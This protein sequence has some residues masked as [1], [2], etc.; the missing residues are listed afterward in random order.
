MPGR[1][2]R[3]IARTC[4]DCRGNNGTLGGDW[5]RWELCHGGV[6]QVMNKSDHYEQTRAMF[7]T[8][9]VEREGYFDASLGGPLVHSV[10]QL[11]VRR[12]LRTMLAELLRRDTE[13]SSLV[14]LGCG[15]GDL[16]LQISEEHQQ[17]T[18]VVGTDFS[19]ECVALSRRNTAERPTISFERA[20]LRELPYPDGCFDIAMCL[21]TLHHVR[22]ED[23]RQVF[24]EV[25][26]VSRHHLLVEIKNQRNLYYGHLHRTTMDGLEVYP[27]TV[28][29]LSEAVAGFGFRLRAKRGIFWL[30]RL[31]PLVVLAFEREVARS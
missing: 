9:A 13:S 31:S 27:T 10:W 15:N 16:T 14:D 28:E 5:R 18:K 4:N 24:R 25:A 3:V 6:E 2:P 26:R 21:D 22:A 12:I 23:H 30:E 11:R 1:A 7:D 17:L 8:S 20:D 29:R 19:A